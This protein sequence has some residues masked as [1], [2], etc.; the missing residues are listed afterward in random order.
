MMAI[1]SSTYSFDGPVQ[2]D[3]RRWIKEIH[4]DSIAGEH[5]V[6]Y[7]ADADVDYQSVANARA[8][9]IALS[10]AEQEFEGILNDG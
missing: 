10:L 8:A 5:S 1:V 3:G 9:Q 4:T 2:S 6:Y 7:L